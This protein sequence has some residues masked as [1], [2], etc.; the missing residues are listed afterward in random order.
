M[1]PFMMC[2]VVVVCVWGV[3]YFCD[4]PSRQSKRKFQSKDILQ[5]IVGQTVKVIES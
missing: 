1:C 3:L 2:V 4:L 5:I